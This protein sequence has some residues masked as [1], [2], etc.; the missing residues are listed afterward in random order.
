MPIL[1]L[2]KKSISIQC[3]SGKTPSS[4]DFCQI[5]IFLIK[6][7]LKRFQISCYTNITA[8]KIISQTPNLPFNNHVR[9]LIN[10][11]VQYA[12]ILRTN[13]GPVFYSQYF[14][15]VL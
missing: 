13:N 7:Y 10:N 14:Y 6:L 15:L 5:Q 9:H 12:K 11:I 3:V 2:Q 8:M 4:R 1:F